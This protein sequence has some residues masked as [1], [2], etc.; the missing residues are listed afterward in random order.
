M[1]ESTSPPIA[2]SPHKLLEYTSCI[3]TNVSSSKPIS[4]CG[5]I[6]AHSSFDLISQARDCDTLVKPHENNHRIL[7]RDL[8]RIDNDTNK[9]IIEIQNKKL[10]RTESISLPSTPI[11]HLSSKYHRSLFLTPPNKTHSDDD[12]DDDDLDDDDDDDD[13]DGI[14]DRNFRYAS[15]TD[16]MTA[17]PDQMPDGSI[18]DLKNNTVSSNSSS[19]SPPLPPPPPLLLPPLSETNIPMSYGVDWT[20]RTYST[21]HCWYPYIPTDLT[22][23]PACSFFSCKNPKPSLL[24]A[25]VQCESCFLIVHTH[26][27]SNL[28]T[29]QTNLM[30][31]CR[32]SF[33]DDNDE[34]NKSDQH[35]WSNISVLS[36]PCTFCKRKS[37]SNPIFSGNNRP[38]TMP[39]LDI[40]TKGITYSKS[41]IPD[42]PKLSGS[43]GG[44][45]CLWCSRGYHRRCWEQIFNHED[46]NKCDYGVFRQIIVRPQWIRRLPGYTPLFRAQYFNDNDRGTNYT[47]LLLFINKRSGGQSGEKIYRKLLHLLNPRQVFLLENDRTIIDALDIYSSLSNI[48]ICVF[49]GD[50]TVGWVLSCLAEIYPSL[51]NPP[52]CICPLGTGNDLSRVLSWGEQYD[53]KRL[54]STLIQIPHAKSIALDRWQVTLEPLAQLIL[55][56]RRRR[57]RLQTILDEHFYHLLHNRSLFVIQLVP[58]IKIIVHYQIVVL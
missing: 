17:T 24:L 56:R 33:F 23:S 45:Q 48:R 8:R 25:L 30:P 15:S 7:E 49:G 52:V 38:S 19:T 46:R 51:N 2:R 36:K 37:M 55:I 22:S 14:D 53:P 5:N 28:S 54:L 18:F 27:L 41:P 57:R 21:S 47:P 16:Y 13:D 44:L 39:T 6:N 32:P 43:T 10:D 20:D 3:D 26:H 11:E 34:P 1:A 58:H 50:G 9:H 4:T 29:I 31:S 40:M 42:S 12:D 35:F